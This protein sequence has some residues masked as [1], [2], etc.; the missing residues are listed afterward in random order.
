MRGGVLRESVDGPDYPDMH[1][2]ALYEDAVRL[3]VKDQELAGLDLVTDGNQYYFQG[4]T[5]YDKVQMLLVP[6]RLQGFR[7]YG[8][9]G[10]IPGTEHY[11]RPVV[12]DRIRWV[13]PIFGAVLAAMKQATDG[14]FKININSGP[15]A[16][17]NW[18]QDEYYGEPGSLRADIAEAFNH[19]LRWLADQGARFIQLT[20]QTYLGSAGQQRWAV[21]L[22]NQAARGVKAHL[23][24]HMCYGNSRESD[25]LYPGVNA[26]CLAELFASGQSIDWHEIHMETARPGMSEVGALSAWTARDGKYL[27]IGVLEVMNPHVETP[28]QVAGRIR[29]ALERVAAGRLI[30]STDCGLYQLPRDLA[31]RKLRSLVAGTRIVRRELG[32]RV[33]GTP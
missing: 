27:G 18:C 23:T 4:E 32:R 7:A 33:D 15:A 24:W 8:P 14:P 20:E 1:Q 11:F 30:I 5:P 21:D 31:F 17:A 19:E 10:T 26:S 16:V 3:C 22:M 28:E 29:A 6:L 9:P 13:R 2:R 12:A 25:S